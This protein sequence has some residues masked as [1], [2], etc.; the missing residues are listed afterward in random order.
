MALRIEDA[1]AGPRFQIGAPQYDSSVTRGGRTAPLAE[2]LRHHLSR[3]HARQFPIAIR[4][5]VTQ[6]RRIDRIQQFQIV[7]AYIF[8]IPTRAGIAWDGPFPCRMSWRDSTRSHERNLL[9]ELGFGYVRERKAFRGKSNLR[10]PSVFERAQISTDTEI[11]GDAFMRSETAGPRRTE[12]TA[13]REYWDSGLLRC[14]EALRRRK[15]H[16][17]RLDPSPTFRP[18]VRFPNFR[19]AWPC[20]DDDARRDNSASTSAHAVA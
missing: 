15:N 9:H 18:A 2:H 1:P 3:N 19:K 11:I 12:P 4:V 5:G 13:Y 10:T 7:I 20:W 16:G 14:S 17:Q 8:K 6:S